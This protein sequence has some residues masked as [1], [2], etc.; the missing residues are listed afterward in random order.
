[1]LVCGGRGV[2]DEEAETHV[3]NEDDNVDVVGGAAALAISVF[4][5]ESYI[6]S[7]VVRRKR[8]EA[9][10]LS[11]HVVDTTHLP[12]HEFQN[13]FILECGR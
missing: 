9:Q 1:M 12:Q 13:N 11:E 8:L 10:I 6:F 7:D 4:G 5:S 3:E 2:K